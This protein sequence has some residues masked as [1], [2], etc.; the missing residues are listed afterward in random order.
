MQHVRIM[1]LCGFA[2]RVLGAVLLAC[3][4]AIYREY[5]RVL[6]C[7]MRYMGWHV[8]PL[9]DS[10]LPCFFARVIEKT[11]RSTAVRWPTSHICPRVPSKF[12][13]FL[14]RVTSSSNAQAVNDFTGERFVRKWLW[15]SATAAVT[16]VVTGG[17]SGNTASTGGSLHVGEQLGF[18]SNSPNDD[19]NSDESRQPD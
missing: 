14:S 5:C 15:R 6:V 2:G 13:S 19:Y 11:A 3:K 17:T 8:C 12:F 7:H 18:R 1:A 4:C 10:P 9:R 16:T